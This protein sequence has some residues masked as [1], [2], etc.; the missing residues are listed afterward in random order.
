MVL[1]LSINIKCAPNYKRRKYSQFFI[2]HFD[3]ISDSYVILNP[4]KITFVS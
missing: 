1:I 2:S 4:L 3:V